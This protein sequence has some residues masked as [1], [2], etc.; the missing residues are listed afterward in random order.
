MAAHNLRLSDREC[1]V[2]RFLSAQYQNSSQDVDIAD[3]PG[4]SD[5]PVEQR[6]PFIDRLRQRG[7]VDWFCEASITILPSVVDTVYEMDHPPVVNEWTAMIQWWFSARWRA[8]VTAVAVV[9]PLIVQW[10]QMIQTVLSWC[11]LSAK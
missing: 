3:I 10:I 8:A 4:L 7:F 11:G 1:D 6:A 9:L 2:L 5:L